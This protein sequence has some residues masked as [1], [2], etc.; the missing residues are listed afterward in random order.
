MS[1]AAC[2]AC[3]DW[4]ARALAAEAEL[5]RLRARPRPGR[6]PSGARDEKSRLVAAACKARKMSRSELADVLDIE[7][8]RL[9]PSGRFPEDR[10]EELLAKLR[11]M[12]AEKRS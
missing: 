4:K 1:T 2:P 3:E 7:R 8:A 6:K 9:S 12:A 5:A 11:E 10:R